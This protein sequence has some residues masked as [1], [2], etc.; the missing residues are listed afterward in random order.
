M[1]EVEIPLDDPKETIFSCV[2]KVALAQG[3][4]K[5]ERIRRIWEPTYTWVT[6]TS[7]VAK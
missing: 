7:Y 2:Q 5:N 4:T 6:L 1:S 3:S